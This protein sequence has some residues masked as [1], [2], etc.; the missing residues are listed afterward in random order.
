[1][2]SAK[3]IKI[4]IPGWLSVTLAP[5][6][7]ERRAAWQLYVELA[8]RIALRPFDRSTG[9]ARSALESLYGV[10]L[11]TRQ[12]LK[13]AGPDVA[14]SENAFGP[15]AIRFLTEVLTPFLLRWHEPLRD[16]EATR[17]E[18]ESVTS[19]EQKW[20]RYDGLCGELASLQ[21][22]TRAYT[23]ALA[24]IAGVAPVAS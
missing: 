13:D 20:D 21:E 18:K 12:I 1:M 24:K 17:G 11:L 2:H 7:S 6:E 15:L 16:Y 23:S 22:K 19:H 14:L 5:N 4:S 10:V 9:S 3:E 8:T